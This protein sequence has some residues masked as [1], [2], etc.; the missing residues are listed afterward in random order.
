MN[1]V[2]TAEGSKPYQNEI[3]D[4]L[5]YCQQ[6]LKVSITLNCINLYIKLAL[7]IIS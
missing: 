4:K 1:N 3:L 5:S 2:Y 6:Y 7:N